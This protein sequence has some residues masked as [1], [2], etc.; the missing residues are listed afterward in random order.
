MSL[1]FLICRVR[2]A[3]VPVIK[4]A[5][6]TK[7]ICVRCFAQPYKVSN[8][9]ERWLSM[10]SYLRWQ[11][12]N[13]CLLWGGRGHNALEDITGGS[14]ERGA[15]ELEEGKVRTKKRRKSDLG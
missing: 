14:L 7:L 13:P 6:W 9:S 15:Q 4:V 2:V 12:V 8:K 5:V 10:F 1:S 3:V 11:P